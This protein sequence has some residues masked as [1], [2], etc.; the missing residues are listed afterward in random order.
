MDRSSLLSLLLIAACAGH[1]SPSPEAAPAPTQAPPP[2]AVSRAMPE[3][4]I[5]PAP[6]ADSILDRELVEA[7]RIAAHSAADKPILERLADLHPEP[8]DAAAGDDAPA[9]EAPAAAD[10]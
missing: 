9:E 8:P 6:L 1:P 10:G 7:L 5:V 2:P 3:S 4:E